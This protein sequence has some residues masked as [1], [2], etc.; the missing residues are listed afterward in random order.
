MPCTRGY[1]SSEW[2]A[3]NLESRKKVL[4]RKSVVRVKNILNDDIYGRWHIEKIVVANNGQRYAIIPDHKAFNT[5]DEAERYAHMR[6]QQFVTRKLGRSGVQWI[7][8]LI[9]TAL[10]SVIAIAAILRYSVSDRENS[11]VDIAA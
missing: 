10:I 9:T 5:K 11:S 7:T 3:E 6:T 1:T 2:I 4:G 8:A